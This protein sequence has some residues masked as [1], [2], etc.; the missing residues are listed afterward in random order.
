M[1]IRLAFPA[2]TCG[3]QADGAGQVDGPGVEHPPVRRN[4]PGRADDIAVLQSFE[5][6]RL[7]PRR[8]DLERDLAVPDQVELVGG[9]AFV[10][11]ELPGVEAMVLRA[12]REQLAMLL[13]KA[14][15]NGCSLRMRSSP[16]I[17]LLHDRLRGFSDRRSFFCDVDAHGTP[18]YA[19]ATA[20]AA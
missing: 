8:H 4:E 13:G 6:N 16:S 19:A 2:K 14:A 11:H 9:V 18:G 17:V 1:M 20:H 10:K 7:P 12:A 15:K 5:D 3:V